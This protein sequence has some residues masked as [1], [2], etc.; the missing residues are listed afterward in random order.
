MNVFQL[1]VIDGGKAQ[2]LQ[3]ITFFPVVDNVAQAEQV[4][5][6][7]Q[8]FLCFPYGARYTKTETRPLINLYVHPAVTLW[9]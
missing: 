8:F 4:T 9:N 7:I 3:A 1:F 6:F 2:T 5:V